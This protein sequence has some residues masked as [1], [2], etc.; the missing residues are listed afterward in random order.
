MLVSLAAYAIPLAARVLPTILTGLTTD[1]F[2]DGINKAI[3]GSG[4]AGDGV[5]LHKHDKCYR[6]QKC[7]GNGL[8]SCTS[9][10]CKELCISSLSLT[11]IVEQF[12]ERNG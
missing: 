10:F 3:S 9:T 1:L 7:K 6:E 12:G 2:S 8:S 11:F 5:Y 4:A